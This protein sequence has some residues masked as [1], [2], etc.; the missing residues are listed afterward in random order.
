[1][2]SWSNSRNWTSAPRLASSYRWVFFGRFATLTSIQGDR[3]LCDHES[4][5]ILSALPELRCTVPTRADQA[6][7][8]WPSPVPQHASIGLF[9][10]RRAAWIPVI[11]ITDS[12]EAGHA[13]KFRDDAMARLTS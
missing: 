6:G 5:R 13:S 10:E 9:A 7:I 1:V 4:R 12:D 11:V 2:A 8:S 3:I